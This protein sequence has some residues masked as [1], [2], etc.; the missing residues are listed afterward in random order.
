MRRHNQVTM[1]KTTV[2]KRTTIMEFKGDCVHKYVIL[3]ECLLGGK[4]M[5]ARKQLNPHQK[6][7]HQGDE[8]QEG[9]EI[10]GCRNPSTVTKQEG[11]HGRNLRTTIQKCKVTR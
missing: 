2:K 11:E 5:N 10:D 8:N 4:Q 6:W 3:D 9:M 7:N 1:L